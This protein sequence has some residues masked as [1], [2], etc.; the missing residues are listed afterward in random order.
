MKCLILILSLVIGINSCTSK[1]PI[2]KE[3]LDF[4]FS[5]YPSLYDHVRLEV[6]ANEI[7]DTIYSFQAF[8]PES[9]A[10][11][12]EATWNQKKSFK[13]KDEAIAYTKGYREERAKRRAKAL[14]K[15]MK[16]IEVIF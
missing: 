3:K 16:S 6:Q 11:C 14:K 13:S 7:G 2:K 1:K 5:S 15:Q 8:Y 12:Y 9:C 10:G 4:D